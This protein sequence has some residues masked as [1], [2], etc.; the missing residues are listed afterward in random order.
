MNPADIHV[1]WFVVPLV[2]AISLVYSASRHEAW[3]KILGQALRLCGM[4]FTLLIV[5][6]AILLA[7]NTQI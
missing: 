5:T 4:I 7:I 3:P 6:T 1:Y 2:V